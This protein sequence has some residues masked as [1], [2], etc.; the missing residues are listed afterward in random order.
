MIVYTV[1]RGIL[2]FFVPL[3]PESEKRQEAVCFEYQTFT[4]YFEEDEDSWFGVHEE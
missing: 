4:S 1:D 3:V 2:R